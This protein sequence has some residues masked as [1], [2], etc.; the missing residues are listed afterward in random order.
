MSRPIL[1]ASLLVA[2]AGCAFGPGEPYA[3]LA[4][5][6][7]ARVVIAPGRDAG[8][9]WQKLST[10]FEV[11][12]TALRLETT[13]IALIDAGDAAPLSFNPA[14]PP[15]GY[16]LCHAG[17][18]H[19]DDGSLPTYEE[20]EAEIT[21]REVTTVVLA[22][23][24][25]GAFDLLDGSGGALTCE[26]DCALGPSRIARATLPVTRLLLEGAVRDGRPQPRFEGERPIRL[27]ATGDP[28]LTLQWE[29]DVPADRR[30]P[31]QIA[32]HLKLHLTA[33]L[34]DGLELDTLTTDAG[35]IDLAAPENADAR[36]RVLRNL[37]ET[38]LEADVVRND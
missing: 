13:R 31:P 18:C 23:L 14:Q 35:A 2:L 10:D 15:P 29:L 36:A 3:V 4:P 25:G 20:V 19:K 9:G 11:R 7:D 12:F 30:E 37:A 26:P 8:E 21:G 1:I 27:E 28:L 33:A 17:H 32:L 38:R 6:I 16:S 34:L 5:S 22:E 24:P